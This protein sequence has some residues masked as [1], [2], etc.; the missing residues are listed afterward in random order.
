MLGVKWC[1]YLFQDDLLSKNTCF[2][3]TF[4]ISNV[5][6]LCDIIHLCYVAIICIICTLKS[7]LNWFDN[8]WG[9]TWC[10]ALVFHHELVH[11]LRMWWWLVLQTM[12]KGTQTT[13]KNV[14]WYYGILGMPHLYMRVRTSYVDIVW[15]THYIRHDISYLYCLATWFQYIDNLPFNDVKMGIGLELEWVGI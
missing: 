10:F 6:I 13:M 1:A 12:T 2:I 14:Q 9:E 3:L 8:S 11:S 5:D 7:V 15:W 4:M